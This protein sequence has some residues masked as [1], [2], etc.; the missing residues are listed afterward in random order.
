MRAN[1]SLEQ[2][3]SEI[4]EIILNGQLGE[5]ATMLDDIIDLSSGEILTSINK[6]LAIPANL[7]MLTRTIL[8][9]P[10][11]LNKVVEESY[12]HENGFHKIV[13]LSGRNFKLRLHHFG[14]AAKI[15]MENIHDH[16]WPFASTILSGELKMDIFRVSEQRKNTEALYHFIYGSDKSNGSY[17]TDLVGKVYLEKAETRIYKPG[18]S[19]LMLPDELHRIKNSE[20]QES[21]TLILTGKPVGGQ[22]NLYAKRHILDKERKTITYQQED[23]SNML[24]SLIEKIYPQQN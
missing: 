8:N 14:V 4:N 10:A 21:V 6:M 2:L 19:Y 23:L 22:C 3:Q 7:S 1:I 16:R 18:E 17:T 13:L 5:L 24:S 11:I 15:P 9:N 20:G 12:Y